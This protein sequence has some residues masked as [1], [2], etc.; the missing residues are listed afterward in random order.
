MRRTTARWSVFQ[1]YQFQATP[2]RAEGPP[3][4]K[5]P[6]RMNLSKESQ[7]VDPVENDFPLRI[8]GGEPRPDVPEDQYVDQTFA[9]NT[10]IPQFHE[11]QPWSSRAP[12]NSFR[13][14]PYPEFDETGRRMITALRN[15][16]RSPGSFKEAYL[17][18]MK[19][20]RAPAVPSAASVMQRELLCRRGTPYVDAID[21]QRDVGRV[22]P[23]TP[24]VPA[25]AEA[26]QGPFPY[27]WNAED[28][29][30]Y[31]VASVRMLRFK[32]ENLDAPSARASEVT[33]K[34]VLGAPWEHH[35]APFANDVAGFV[36]DIGRQFLEEKLAAVRAT[37]H[38]YESANGVDDEL[39]RAFNLG[40]EQYSD[41]EIAEFAMRDLKQL[42]IDCV[43]TLSLIN[44]TQADFVD[45]S[46]ASATWPVVE[47]IEPWRR[48][49]EFWSSHNDTTFNQAEMST[50]KYEFRRFFRVVVIK[51]PFVSAEFERRLYDIRHWLHR[52]GSVE[53]QTVHKKSLIY[54]A[55]RFPV[56][57]DPANPPSHLDHSMYSF[58]LDWQQAPADFARTIAAREGDSFESL[59]SRLG[60]SS[61]AVRAANPHVHEITAGMTITLPRS[62]AALEL[63]TPAVPPAVVQLSADMKTWEA[64]AE[65]IGVTVEELQHANPNAVATYEDGF[66]V[67]ELRV[68]HN[69]GGPSA[70]EFAAVERTLVTDTFASV[71]KRLGTSEASLRAAN[72]GVESPASVEA[73][74]VP[75]DATRRRRLRHSLSRSEFDTAE[76]FPSLIAERDQRQLPGELPS[77]PEVADEFPDE[78]PDER[79]PRQPKDL[80]GSD[81]WVA[82]TAAYLDRELSVTAEPGA[83]YAV[84][85][86]WPSQPLPGSRQQ[87]PFEEDQTWMLARTP[88][89]QHEIFNP[90]GHLQDLPHINNEQFEVSL[91]RQAP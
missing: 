85:P 50:R 71:A 14:R 63:A 3:P 61:R 28:W 12:E 1:L 4:A 46:D 17:S 79:Y 45:R 30:E 23:A 69:Y 20:K 18:K 13:F 32:T 24:K 81:S 16:T 73:V 22:T 51:M 5:A 75:S 25:S 76:L 67:A 31:E 52:R 48:M 21:R 43:R 59:A 64:A 90:E 38:A 29:Y 56:E 86:A 80:R 60:C 77:R 65:A 87:T 40:S 78:F 7:F 54:D 84:H 82:Y 11:L 58:A 39:R 55:A 72:P 91:R 53:F 9:I 36:A 6:Q 70:S 66:T 10:A 68:P 42:E 62:R 44:A 57:H 34:L 74:Q 26:S 41:E 19:G 33:Y 47:T 37:L 83:S 2:P 15:E 88:M 89:Q 27:E 8:R 49:V 35:M